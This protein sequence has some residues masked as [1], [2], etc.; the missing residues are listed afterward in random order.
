[1]KK[2]NLLLRNLLITYSIE[3]MIYFLIMGKTTMFSNMSYE[4]FIFNVLL[5]TFVITNSLRN[6]STVRTHST[7]IIPK[8]HTEY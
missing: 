5:Y 6:N 3:L 4:S 8:D 1:M 2:L 7:I